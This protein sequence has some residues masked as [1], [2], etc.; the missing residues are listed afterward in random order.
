MLEKIFIKYEDN[1]NFFVV[2]L[3]TFF[4]TILLGIFCYYTFNHPYVFIGLISL[5]LC[6]PVMKHLLSKEKDVD[7]LKGLKSFITLYRNE[8]F[9]YLSIFLGTS[10][11]ILLMFFLNI[12]KNISI[13]ENIVKLSTGNFFLNSN[14]YNIL[15]NNIGV[16][17]LTFTLSMLMFGGFLFILVWNGSILAYYLNYVVTDKILTFLAILPHL[18][19]EIGG[20]IL[21]G[22]AG[23]IL[24][25]GL[26]YKQEKMRFIK[27]GLIILSISLLFIIIGAF[28]ESA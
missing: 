18:F 14:F 6:Y 3:L 8:L 23:T 20:F 25:Y 28:L 7:K 26:E 24:M 19:F 10:L 17:L 27:I 22:L 9:I 5:A 2:L 16:T 13:Y 15:I 21:A 4:I 12:I 1:Y 11:A